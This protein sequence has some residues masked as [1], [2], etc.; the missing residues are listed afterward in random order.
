MAKIQGLEGDILKRDSKITKFTGENEELE[1][2]VNQHQSKIKQ[3]EAIVEENANSSEIQNKLTK[4]M[5]EL[6]EKTSELGIFLLMELFFV[7]YF[8]FYKSK[9]CAKSRENYKKKSLLLL[10]W[11]SKIMNIRN[12]TRQEISIINF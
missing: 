10:N 4:A 7:A 6:N 1:Q 2:Q 8:K 11:S 12:D 9:I 5:R 3:L